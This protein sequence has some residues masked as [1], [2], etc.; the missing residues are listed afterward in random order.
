MKIWFQNR[1]AKERKH[2]KKRDE[3]IQKEKIEL[4]HATA[5]ALTNAASA[6]NAAL[7]NAANA[8]NNSSDVFNMLSHHSHHQATASA[9]MAN[10]VLRPP[11]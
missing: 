10:A 5:N 8:L 11:V 7:N 6:A 3:I 2:L 1:R 4:H 9:L